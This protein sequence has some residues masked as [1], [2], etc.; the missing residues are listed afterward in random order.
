M[1]ARFASR[2]NSVMKSAPPTGVMFQS[3]R[4]TPGAAFERR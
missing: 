4:M 2:E 1:G 3:R